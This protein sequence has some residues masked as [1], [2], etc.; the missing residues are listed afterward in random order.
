MVLKKEFGRSSAGIG[1]KLA[2]LYLSSGELV[3]SSLFRHSLAFSTEFPS[4]LNLVL[5]NNL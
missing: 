5:E 3:D 2:K 4:D 1:P